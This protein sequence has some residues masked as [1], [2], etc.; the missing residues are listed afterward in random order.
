MD[1]VKLL[2]KKLG[3]IIKRMVSENFVKTEILGI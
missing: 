1:C 2:E 3:I